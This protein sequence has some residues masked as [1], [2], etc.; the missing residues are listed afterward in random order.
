ME[1]GKCAFVAGQCT[2]WSHIACRFSRVCPEEGRCATIGGECVAT[3]EM[4]C[5]RSLACREDGDCYLHRRRHE[6]VDVVRR[7]PSMMGAG[8]AMVSVGG[9]AS[10]AGVVTLSVQTCNITCSEPLWEVGVP[11]LATGGVGLAVG[12]P[13][14]VSGA[15]NKSQL[16]TPTASTAPQLSLAP[17]RATLRWWF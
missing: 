1:D 12:I 9:A 11:L 6:C 4:D 10:L 16:P 5:W 15:R 13:L 8:I 14:I 7:D 17:T 3:D 2:A